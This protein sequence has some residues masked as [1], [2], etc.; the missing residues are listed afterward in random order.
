MFYAVE[1]EVAGGLGN[2]TIMDRSVHPPVVHK[3]HFVF[4]G[5]DGDDILETFPCYIVTEKLR[6]SIEINNFTG[7]EFA[8]VTVDTS[9]NFKDIYSNVKLPKFYWLKV[10][11]IVCKDDFGI[12]QDN[13]LVVSESFKKILEDHVTENCEISLYSQ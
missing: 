4:E 10:N 5:W 8:D 12:S 13:R 3:L 9:E 7:Y 1:P 2:S 6:N 11:G